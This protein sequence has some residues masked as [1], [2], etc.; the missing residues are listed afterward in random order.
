MGIEDL[1]E[2]RRS[3]P[4]ESDQKH[5]RWRLVRNQRRPLFHPVGGKSA[6]Q[7][8]DK[9]R[10]GLPVHPPRVEALGIHTVGIGVHVER[11]PIVP[12]PVENRRHLEQQIGARF[13]LQLSSS[14][15]PPN[16][17]SPSAGRPRRRSQRRRDHHRPHVARNRDAK[18]PPPWPGL[19]PTRSTSPT[20]RREQHGFPGRRERHPAP[21]DTVPPLRRSVP[22]RPEHPP[23]SL[24][25]CHSRA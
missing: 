19:P 5:R 2:Q 13:V 18:P 25:P 15:T 3:G 16:A 11:P 20:K 6:P 4:R 14:R 24:A 21:E 9:T 1:I 7:P 22:T 8:L 23:G 17:P 10:I 12:E